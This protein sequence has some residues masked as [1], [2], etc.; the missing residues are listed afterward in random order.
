MISL[1][2]FHSGFD[3]VGPLVDELRDFE[4]SDDEEITS[5]IHLHN[6]ILPNTAN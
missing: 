3:N 1:P 6:P 4:D 2:G 5:G